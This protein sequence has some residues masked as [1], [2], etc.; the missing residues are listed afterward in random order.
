MRA[1]FSN[2]LE[3]KGASQLHA[4]AISYKDK[5]ILIIGN[6]GAG[7]ITT[8]STM[9]LIEGV[10][11]I[12]NDRV[13]VWNESGKLFVSAWSIRYKI[14]IGT[15]LN[16]PILMKNLNERIIKNNTE[17]MNYNDKISIFNWEIE[18]IFEKK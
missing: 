8:F 7:K 18:N 9:S 3:N 1:L 11:L 5:G 17:I 4:A 6:S 13:I 16:N 14:G 10:D 12:S 2:V 15:I